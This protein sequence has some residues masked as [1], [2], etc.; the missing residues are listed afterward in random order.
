MVIQLRVRRFICQTLD[1]ARRIF[2]EQ[3]GGLTVRHGRR[4]LQMVELLVA[5][6]LAGR[7]GAR[8]ACQAAIHCGPVIIDWHR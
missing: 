5:F 2:A 6:A 3:L 7:A 8:L 1:C 4:S